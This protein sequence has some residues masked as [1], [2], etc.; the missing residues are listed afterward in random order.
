MLRG[1]RPVTSFQDNMIRIREVLF[2]KKIVYKIT[3]AILG[4]IVALSLMIAF[5]PAFADAAET[6]FTGTI[7]DQTNPGILYLDTNGGT[8]Q[9][10]LDTTTDTSGAKFLVPGKTITASCFMGGDSY[11]H[12]KTITGKSSVGAI[13]PDAKQSTVVGVVAKNT[14]ESMLYLKLTEGT[15]ELKLDTTTD[16]SNLKSIII[17]KT[18][19]CV[20][21]RGS[22]AYM[23]AISISDTTESANLTQTAKTDAAS[24]GAAQTAGALPTELNPQNATQA[25]N[26]LA[27]FVQSQ[28]GGTQ[29]ASAQTQEAPAQAAAP[30]T[31]D[32]TGTVDKQT[33]SSVL[34]LNTSGG[35]MQIKIDS[36]ATDS[37]HALITGQTVTASYYRGDDE[38]NHA[39]SLTNNS[40][41]KSQTAELNPSELTVSG[42]VTSKTNEGT[43]FLDTSGGTMQIKLDSD[44]D[45]SGCQVLTQG[46]T[47]EVTCKCGSDE[48][49]HAVAIN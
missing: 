34:F 39:K 44:T 41:K 40:S 4:F 33:T 7:S 9:I 27:A 36:G 10:K 47:V 18:V 19:K 20:V 48:Y 26:A 35:V 14:S 32:V 13:D 29:Q 15:M 30:Q 21:A 46:K 45:F 42:K 49:F 6:S 2:M 17:G 37:C 8:V 38:Y 23:H 25:Q 1:K 24:T 3:G 22:D 5:R 12:A 43:L 16:V 28:Q 31:T 11:W